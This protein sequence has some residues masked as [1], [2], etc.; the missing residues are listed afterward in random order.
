MQNKATDNVRMKQ[1]KS[2][3]NLNTIITPKSS[4]KKKVFSSKDK[5]QNKKSRKALNK[6][7]RKE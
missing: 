3:N 6:E 5:S 7:E 2:I 4:Y 1:A